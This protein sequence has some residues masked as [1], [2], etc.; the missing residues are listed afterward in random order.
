LPLYSDFYQFIVSAT[1]TYLLSI[2]YTCLPVGV[3]MNKTEL[4]LT[5]VMVMVAAVATLTV[6]VI[7]V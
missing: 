1:E 6:S 4:V 2:F 7:L 5:L 3:R